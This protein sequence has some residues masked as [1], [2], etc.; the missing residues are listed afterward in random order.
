MDQLR[1]VWVAL[2]EDVSVYKRLLAFEVQAGVEADSDKHV[3]LVQKANF[4]GG[5]IK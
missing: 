5:D 1:Y 3:V 2:L 4:I